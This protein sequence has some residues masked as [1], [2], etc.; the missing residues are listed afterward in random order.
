MVGS[1][2]AAAGL[3]ARYKLDLVSG[4]KFRSDQGGKVRE[5]NIIFLWKR[6]IKS[7]TKTEFFVHHRIVSAVTL[8]QLIHNYCIARPRIF[9]DYID[10]YPNSNTGSLT[11]IHKFKSRF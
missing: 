4:Q 3:L 8:D 1:L 11:G 7:L 9:Q 6:K 5:R 2:I 10:F